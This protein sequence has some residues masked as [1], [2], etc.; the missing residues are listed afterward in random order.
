MSE[1]VAS[2]LCGSLTATAHGEPADV[3]ACACVDCQR[4]SG[5]AFSY[6]AIYPEAAVS[7]AGEHKTWR[8][9]G[10]SGR[11]VEMGFC[12]SCGVSV[13]FRAEGMSGFIGIAV[14]CF[15]DADFAKPARLYWASRC[16]HWLELGEGTPR[17]ETQP[18]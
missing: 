5:G 1:Q 6:A 10:E 4:K 13:F 16:H 12:P 15:A 8:R 14:G 17:L 3:Y 9:K 18:E 2:C 7:L 11:F